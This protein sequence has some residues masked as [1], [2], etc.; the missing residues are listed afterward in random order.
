MRLESED[1]NWASAELPSFELIV[2]T[3]ASILG[4]SDR[5]AP[6][7]LFGEGIT[8]RSTETL[9]RVKREVITDE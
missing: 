5:V 2:E 9:E 6:E 4:Q 3:P 1:T 8:L 7:K